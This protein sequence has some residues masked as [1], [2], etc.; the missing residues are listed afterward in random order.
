MEDKSTLS[1]ILGTVFMLHFWGGL[2]YWWYLAY[3]LGNWTMWLASLFPPFMVVAVP[4]AIWS[5]YVEVPQWVY[6]TF[7]G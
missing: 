2:W 1:S 5:F 6:G 4:T 3:D 7:G